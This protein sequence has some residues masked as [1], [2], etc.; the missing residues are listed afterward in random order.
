MPCKPYFMKVYT[1][2]KISVLVMFITLFA[3]FAHAAG[4]EVSWSQ[5]PEGDIAG[6]RVYY[7]TSSNDYENSL[8]AGNF[9][10]VEI[11]NLNPGVTYYMAVSAYDTSGNESSLSEEVQ[12]TIPNDASSVL[13]PGS[14]TG[15]EAGGGGG[16]GGCF[17]STSLCE[18]PVSSK[19][20]LV[21]LAGMV[22]IG[23][24][25]KFSSMLGIRKVLR[26]Q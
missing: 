18:D 10:S 24:L 7:G 13:S 14:D 23:M 17:I 6:Y 5:N 20:A 19:A 22:L 4:I 25:S 11:D 8:D 26:R 2:V 9:T 21:V 3:Q 15:A 1:Y 16:G 12:V